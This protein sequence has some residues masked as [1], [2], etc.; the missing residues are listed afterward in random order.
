MTFKYFFV[1]LIIMMV[2]L[3][4]ITILVLAAIWINSISPQAGK[5]PYQPTYDPA[6]EETRK[7]NTVKDAQFDTLS[8]EQKLEYL[9]QKYL[10][11]LTVDMNNECLTSIADTSATSQDTDS[12]S[13]EGERDAA[14]LKRSW[15]YEYGNYFEGFS[16]NE[17]TED[18]MQAS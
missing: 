14:G 6:R 9:T 5:Q 12:E 18:E 16:M 1:Y 15:G 7:N 17:T 4:M 2:V 13:Y 8:K 11:L 3:V 10:T